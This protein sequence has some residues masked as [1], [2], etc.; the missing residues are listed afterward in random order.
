MIWY[1]KQNSHHRGAF[2]PCGC[3]KDHLVGGPFVC[4]GGAADPGAG[5]S[6]GCLA[7][8]PQSGAGPGHYHLLQAGPAAGAAYHP[9]GHPGARGLCP[10]G[11]AGHAGA[12][13]R[14]AGHQRHR[15]GAGSHHHP[16]AAS[17]AVRRAHLPVSE[18]NGLAGEGPGGADAG[19]AGI[20]RPRL[21]GLHPAPGSHLG[22][23]R[24]VRRGSAGNLPG[25]GNRHGR[26]PPGAHSPRK[27]LSL[28]LRLRSETPGGGHPFGAAYHL[29][30]PG[31]STG[32]NLLQ[33]STKSPGTPRATA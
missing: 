31:K 23:R 21:C 14:R 5:G 27:A 30:P 10:G 8:H 6:P 25:N 29:R 32:R 9:A 7:G 20:L 18:Q 1:G 28:L 12:Q 24:S 13:L 33:K 4:G 16:V 17:A 19:I 22:K 15:R 26:K 2:G 3:G 11:G